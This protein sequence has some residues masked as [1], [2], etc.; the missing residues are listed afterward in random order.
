MPTA[1]MQGAKISAAVS[2]KSVGVQG[3]F[4]PPENSDDHIVTGCHHLDSK[5]Y[6]QASRGKE[7]CAMKGGTRLRFGTMTELC[8]CE[9]YK[10]GTSAAEQVAEKL[11]V[12]V[13]LSGAKN[14]SSI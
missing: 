11:T 8:L 5:E 12:S 9:D 2:M 7:I 3:P 14:L 10:I 4:R 6:R 1:Q 13:I